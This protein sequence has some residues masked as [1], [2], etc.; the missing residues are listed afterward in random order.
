M[1]ASRLSIKQSL[2]LSVL[3]FLLIDLIVFRSGLYAKFL[4][5]SSMQGFAQHISNSVI[6]GKFNPENSILIM[7]DSRINEGFSHQQANLTSKKLGIEFFNAGIGGSTLRT[8][9]YLLEQWDPNQDRFKAIVITLP[10]YRNAPPADAGLNSRV[11]DADFLAPNISTKAYLDFI[12]HQEGVKNKIM[13]TSPI[14][15]SAS[16]YSKDFMDLILHPRNRIETYKWKKATGLNFSDAYKGNPDNM[17]GLS[18]DRRANIMKYPERFNADQKK[19]IQNLVIKSSTTSDELLSSSK[20]YSQYWLSRI[21][22][23]YSHSKTKIILLRMPS[24]PVPAINQDA[25]FDMLVDDKHFKNEN[26]YI[27]PENAFLSLEDPKYFWDPNHLNA[28][29]RAALSNQISNT[30]VEY[31][32]K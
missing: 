10:S 18:Y 22:N 11:L 9:C 31:I 20:E 17:V 16:Q 12:F 4:T 13:I 14:F 23:R 26:L 27:I 28:D 2:L 25:N 1:P 19:A 6:A 29:G 5:M 30:L 8:W 7:G 21:I 3:L 32:S 15:V 24:T